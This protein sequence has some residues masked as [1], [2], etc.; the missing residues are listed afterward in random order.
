M[1]PK[2]G[3]KKSAKGEDDTKKKDTAKGGKKGAE[4]T[5][6]T[7]LGN[8]ELGSLSNDNTSS[9]KIATG[10]FV[11]GASQSGTPLDDH[12]NKEPGVS[13]SELSQHTDGNREGGEGGANTGESTSG[14]GLTDADIKYEEPVLPNLIVLR[15]EKLK[16]KLEFTVFLFEL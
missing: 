13:T 3:Q 16:V 8:A 7:A 6:G 1:P 4:E 2:T 11:R 15:F 5:S 10:S 12:A 14:T 9:S